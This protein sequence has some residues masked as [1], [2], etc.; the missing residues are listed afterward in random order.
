MT[1]IP[2]QPGT[3]TKPTVVLVH[4]AFADS[5]SWNDVIARLRRDGYPVIGVANPL[6][7]LQGD[8]AYLRDVLDGVD[9]PIVVAGHSYGGSVLSEAADGHPRVKALVFVASFLLD[10]GESTGDLAGKFPGNELG[11]ALKPVPVRGADGQTADD[12][13]IEQEKFLPIFAADVPA[14]VAGLMAVTQRPILAGA[15]ADR[16]TKAAWKTIPSWTLITLQDLAVPAEAQ[17]FMAERASSNVVEVDASHAVTVSRPDV[18][19]ELIDRAASQ[20]A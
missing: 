4:G 7:S 8:A 15:L 10:A 12:L 11:T 18:V 20:T 14:D 5:S 13:Y 1:T 17:R 6:R 16:A 9:G 2:T 3:G 19:A